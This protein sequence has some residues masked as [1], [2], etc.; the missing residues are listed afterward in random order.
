MR[1]S[2]TLAKIAIAGA[3]IAGGYALG[4]AIG[5]NSMGDAGSQFDKLNQGGITGV[6]DRLKR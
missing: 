1:G 5:R 4:K 6:S 3:S 2:D